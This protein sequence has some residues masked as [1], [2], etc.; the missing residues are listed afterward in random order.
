MIE[1]IDVGNKI[2]S[3]RLDAYKENEVQWTSKERT[4]NKKLKIVK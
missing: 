1:D 3:E 4:L 2:L